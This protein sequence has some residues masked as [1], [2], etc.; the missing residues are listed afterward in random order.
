MSQLESTIASF[1]QKMASRWKLR[2]YLQ[3][4][5]RRVY[6]VQQNLF[7]KG[8]SAHLSFAVVA[9]SAENHFQDFFPLELRCPFSSLT[10]L[11]IQKTHLGRCYQPSKCARWQ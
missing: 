4:I 2:R 8:C 10:Q 9:K 11:T 7:L 3:S 1:L 5:E 6:T